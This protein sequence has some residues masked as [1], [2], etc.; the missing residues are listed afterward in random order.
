MGPD[1]GDDRGFWTALHREGD[2]TRSPGVSC[3][4]QWAWSVLTRA[5]VSVEPA[6][7]VLE[8]E[9]RAR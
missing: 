9:K 7:A 1:D 6:A 8:C 4:V 3:S 5:I 2:R